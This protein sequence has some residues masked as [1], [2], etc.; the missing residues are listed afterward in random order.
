MKIFLL[1]TAAFVFC[2][3]TPAFA[4]YEALVNDNPDPALWWGA[5][6]FGALALVVGTIL[7]MEG[8]RRVG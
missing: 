5:G 1:A 4:F 8:G 6:F 7:Y 3:I 2:V